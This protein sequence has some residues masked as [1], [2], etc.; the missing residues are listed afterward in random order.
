MAKPNVAQSLTLS[1]F[2]CMQ[3][4]GRGSKKQRK[5]K[6]VSKVEWN[7]QS[8]SKVQVSVIIINTMHVRHPG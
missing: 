4:Q 7:K 3:V 6:K 1:Y 8:L 5:V 2:Y